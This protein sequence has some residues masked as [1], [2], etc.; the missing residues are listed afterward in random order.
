MFSSYFLLLLLGFFSVHLNFHLLWTVQMALCLISWHLFRTLFT[1]M[2]LYCYF[3]IFI[4]AN[5]SHWLSTFTHYWFFYANL[6]SFPFISHFRFVLH[7]HSHIQR[8]S[9]RHTSHT[10]R[11]TNNSTSNDFGT[12]YRKRL[13]IICNKRPKKCVYCIC[14]RY[15]D[16]TCT[17]KTNKQT[18]TMHKQ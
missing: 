17:R 6:S 3:L 10:R 11:A 18:K 7:I 14:D 8:C 1:G 2:A 9:I 5:Y 13:R 16:F 12:K 15:S 4:S